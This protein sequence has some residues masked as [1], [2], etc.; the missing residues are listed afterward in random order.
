[1]TNNDGPLSEG[2][3]LDADKGEVRF[4]D[5]VDEGSPRVSSAGNARRGRAGCACACVFGSVGGARD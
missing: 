2:I 4:G 5:E 3:R 1:M